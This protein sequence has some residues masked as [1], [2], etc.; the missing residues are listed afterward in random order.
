MPFFIRNLKLTELSFVDRPANPHA[1]VVL[2]K[3]YVNDHVKITKSQPPQTFEEAF[4]KSRAD[5]PSM[6]RTEALS[7]CRR[8]YPTLFSNYQ[9]APNKSFDRQPIFK[10]STVVSF[11]KCIDDIQSRNRISRLEAMRKAAREFP[12][13]C[14]AYRR[15]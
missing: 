13:E 11:E 2:F 6:L 12:M 1:R 10:S 7:R 14:E 9:T 4:N 8:E 3:R 5:N 15:A